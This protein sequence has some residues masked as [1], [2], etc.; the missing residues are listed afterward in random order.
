MLRH[1]AFPAAFMAM[2]SCLASPAEAETATVEVLHLSLQEASD[3]V[4]S[5]LSRQGAVARLPSRQMLVIQDDRT[6]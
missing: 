3:A 4:K 1:H 5:Q 6:H 2:L